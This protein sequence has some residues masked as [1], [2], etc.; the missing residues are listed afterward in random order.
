M[1]VYTVHEPPRRSGD[2]LAHTSRFRFVRDGFH[3]TAFLFAELTDVTLIRSDAVAV[4]LE[5][6][7]GFREGIT[8]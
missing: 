7:R 6:V 4:R 5:S 8:H 1:P 2:D 3:W